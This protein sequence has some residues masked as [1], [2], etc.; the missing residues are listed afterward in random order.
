MAC[1]FPFSYQLP[2]ACALP[3]ACVV[4]PYIPDVDGSTRQYKA[5]IS[6]YADADLSRPMLVEGLEIW[7]REC[8]NDPWRREDVEAS[9]CH[10]DNFAA[11]CAYQSVFACGCPA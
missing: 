9:L 2:F 11:S 3:I 4:I 10:Q 7:Y 5:W 6:K 8:A 1:S